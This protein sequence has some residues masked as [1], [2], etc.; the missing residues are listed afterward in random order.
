MK[1]NKKIINEKFIDKID[2]FHKCDLINKK[3]P[4]I[5]EIIY[6]YGGIDLFKLF[7]ERNDL[8]EKIDINEFFKNF[9]NIIEG[10]KNINEK[11]Y[12]HLDIKE[13][14]ILYNH[15]IKKFSLIDFGLS[16]EYNN[17]FK[18]DIELKHVFI[19]SEFYIISKLY[20][21]SK[22]YIDDFNLYTFYEEIFKDQYNNIINKYKFNNLLNLFNNNKKINIIKKLE[23]INEK[24]KKDLSEDSLNNIITLLKIDKTKSSNSSEFNLDKYIEKICTDNTDIRKKYDVYN[25]GLT[26]LN[27]ILNL[28]LLKSNNSI[29]DIPLELFDLIIKMIDI[30]PCLR[31]T[32]QEAFKEYDRIFSK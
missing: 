10:V 18:L 27:I 14:N 30:N 3:T 12:M 8:M 28:L 24:I 17:Y 5:Y 31:I 21:K 25:I 9:K 7:N 16:A 11:G 20:K 23:E 22:I 19:P 15:E 26:L 32:I 1:S 29:Y 2:S 4:T 6:E 13:E